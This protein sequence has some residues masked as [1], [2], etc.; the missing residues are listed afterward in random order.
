MEL[1]LQNWFLHQQFGKTGVTGV[2]EIQQRRVIH[3][4]K[5]N[6]IIYN[7]VSVHFF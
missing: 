6:K 4:W 5:A 1:K 3:G 7:F 2:L